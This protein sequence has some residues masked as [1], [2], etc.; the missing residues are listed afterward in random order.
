MLRNP[1]L[2]AEVAKLYSAELPYHNFEH[3]LQ[4][5]K[6]AEQIVAHCREEGIRIDEQVVYY[7]ILFHD[8]G[9][10]D[11]HSAL[12][13]SCKEEYSAH[14]AERLLP[15]H[16]VHGVMLKKVRDAIMATHRDGKFVSAEQKAVRAADLRGLAADYPAFLA[17]AE[18]LRA[19]S[20]LLTGREISW[21]E[22]VSE[23]TKTIRFYLTQEI[24]LTSY[25][26]DE[27]GASAF[28]EQVRAN[29]KMLQMSVRS[30]VS[31]RITEPE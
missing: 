7:A 15:A 11:D 31:G 5:V 28:H 30:D 18:R 3:A 13:F 26:A 8:A 22:W 24:R 19:E 27:S 14:L 23:V 12:G 16:G 17:N 20:E 29:L 2:E 9:F 21:P 1:A 4:A 6:D 25:F 10:H